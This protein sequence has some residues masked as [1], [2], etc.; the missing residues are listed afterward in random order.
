MDELFN[1]Q[2]VSVVR[3]FVSN[4]GNEKLLD[5]ISKVILLTVEDYLFSYIN[6]FQ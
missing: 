2:L 5:Y 4:A 3:L 6:K 1:F